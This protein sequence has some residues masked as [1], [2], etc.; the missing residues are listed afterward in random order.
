MEFWKN[1]S[2]LRCSPYAAHLF[3]AE[4]FRS[5]T[6]SFPGLCTQYCRQLYEACPRLADVIGGSEGPFDDEA[7]FCE[8]ARLSDESYC[9]P[10]VEGLD[11]QSGRSLGSFGCLCVQVRWIYCWCK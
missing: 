1:V 5:A 9:Y 3:D 8:A 2:C 7:G 6:R 4:G 10:D 11:V